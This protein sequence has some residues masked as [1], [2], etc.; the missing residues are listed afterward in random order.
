MTTEAQDNLITL[1]LKKTLRE[2]DKIRLF[3]KAVGIT[4]QLYRRKYN[5][6]ILI[7]TVINVHT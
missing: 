4:R 2:L 5:V 6:S 3:V 7:D 1:A